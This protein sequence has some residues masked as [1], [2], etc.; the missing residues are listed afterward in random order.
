LKKEVAL[1]A[2]DALPPLAFRATHRA[3]EHW[4]V[5]LRDQEQ[6]V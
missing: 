4:Q 5:T 1:F 3:L 2:V 6:V